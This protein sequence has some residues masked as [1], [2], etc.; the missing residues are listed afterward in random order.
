MHTFGHC[1]SHDAM[2]LVV[3]SH[4]GQV[5]KPQ[6][7]EK[8]CERRHGPLTKVCGQS[9]APQPRP[10]S[11]RSPTNNSFSRERQ[12]DGRCHE[13]IA[14]SSAAPP[15]HQHMP[16]TAQKEAV[17]YLLGLFTSTVGEK[18]ATVLRHKITNKLNHNQ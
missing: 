6:A 2:Y 15:A 11:V 13:A 4:C 14:P 17:R 10:R 9:P 18:H 5:V 1:P 16:S 12:K 3:C 8:H 7:F